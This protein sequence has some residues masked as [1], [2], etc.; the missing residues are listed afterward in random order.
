MLKILLERNRYIEFGDNCKYFDDRFDKICHQ[1]QYSRKALFGAW[2]QCNQWHCRMKPEDELDCSGRGYCNCDTQ[3]PNTATYCEC[4]Q[5]FYGRFC[6]SDNVNYTTT[7]DSE[8][9]ADYDGDGVGD[10]Y[11]SD[12]DNDGIPDVFEI[13][14]SGSHAGPWK[15]ADDRRATLCPRI[16]VNLV[17]GKYVIIAS[18]CS[19]TAL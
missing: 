13:K 9:F 7:A 5:G 12:D 1:H 17:C 4:D 2:C 8:D 10:E 18:R 14:Y 11:D 6:E 3:D 19:W 15:P 16:K